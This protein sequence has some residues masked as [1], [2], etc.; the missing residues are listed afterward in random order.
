[1][2]F[3]TV[4]AV[5]LAQAGSLF[6]QRFTGDGVRGWNWSSTKWKSYD[7]LPLGTATCALQN[8][9][10]SVPSSMPRTWA[11]PQGEQRRRRREPAAPHLRPVKVV[12]AGA[13][14]GAAAG[15][16]SLGGEVA[17]GREPRRRRRGR[18]LGRARRC[19]GD[20]RCGVSSGR[21]RLDGGCAGA[22]DPGA[23][24]RAP[25]RRLRGRGRRCRRGRLRP[26]EQERGDAADACE[27]ADE[28]DQQWQGSPPPL[29]LGG[30]A[31]VARGGRPGGGDSGRQ[32]RHR[33]EPVR[34]AL[35]R[36]RACA[37]R[38]ASDRP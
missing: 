12:G 2:P 10:L 31:A 19:R 9:G 18:P 21:D 11:Q 30:R 15:L 37:A 17:L 34:V 36:R 4:K 27:D 25:R 3:V 14:A 13:G 29:R 20:R 7:V 22:R 35:H 38:P 23:G 5:G 32:R 24:L 1:M 6:A 8:Q 28:P 26:G 16:V 33:R